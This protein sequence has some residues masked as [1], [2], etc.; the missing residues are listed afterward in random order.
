MLV[1]MA[2]DL[3]TELI[4]GVVF[5]FK[6]SGLSLGFL[7]ID[8]VLIVRNCLQLSLLVFESIDIDVALV[9]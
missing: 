5:E 2:Q 6:D 9:A 4:L 3:Q 1:P 7:Q 8:V